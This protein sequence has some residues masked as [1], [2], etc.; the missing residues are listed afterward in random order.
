MAK[1]LLNQQKER[2]FEEKLVPAKPGSDKLFEL[3]YGA[4]ESKP[5]KCLGLSFANEEARRAY[6]IEKLRA[7]LQDPRRVNPLIRGG[8]QSAIRAVDRHVRAAAR[9]P[10]RTRERGRALTESQIQCA[11]KHLR[12]TR[13]CSPL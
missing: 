2:L 4:E 11:D 3:N 12:R 8:G 10:R 1:K 6:F 7:K 5:V 13:S 9:N